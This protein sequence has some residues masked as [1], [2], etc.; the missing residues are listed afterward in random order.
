MQQDTTPSPTKP[1]SRSGAVLP[2]ILLLL[3][4]A[5]L[6]AFAVYSNNI[7]NAQF[8]AAV[9]PVPTGTPD[10]P[11]PNAPVTC[12]NEPMV[13]GQIC[14]HILTIGESS[15]TTGYS[16]DEQKEYQQ[17]NRIAQVANAR[18]Q[19]RIAQGERQKPIFSLFG[20]LSTISCL[21]GLF[22]AGVALVTFRGKRPR[23]KVQSS[24]PV[25]GTQG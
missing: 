1:G 19:Q 9:T 14:D 3:L 25:P 12:D 7:D 15:T 4:G 17:Q 10:D 5:V 21:A 6:V 22:L 16:Y 20:C 18:E 24:P 2:G 11:D 8:Q 13:Q 23:Q